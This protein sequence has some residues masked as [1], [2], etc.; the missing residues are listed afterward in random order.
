MYACD[1]KNCPYPL[2][3][4]DVDLHMPNTT[5]SFYEHSEKIYCPQSLSL[6]EA[7]KHLIFGFYE[8]FEGYQFLDPRLM[9]GE[10][11]ILEDLENEFMY[12]IESP[13]YHWRSKM[14][15]NNPN[16]K[17][18]FF[19]L[20]DYAYLKN[21]EE[22]EAKYKEMFPVLTPYPIEQIQSFLP[23][24]IWPQN[25]EIHFGVPDTRDTKLYNIW[26]CFLAAVPISRQ[27][28]VFEFLIFL[29]E[30]REK[31]V[32]WLLKLSKEKSENKE[33]SYRVQD[34]LNKSRMFSQNRIVKKQNFDKKTQTY[35]TL[36]ML[37]E[38]TIRNFIS[39]EKGFS[40]YR[41]IREMEKPE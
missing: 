4:V 41:L 11:V 19:E 32:E 26:Q 35:K 6:E 31:V 22:D 25:P 5:S 14:R 1:E 28:E 38:E 40:L 17:H 9:L 33:L 23:F 7:N 36:D 24:T 16:L 8:G 10:F 15:N 39:K 21:T 27:A 37:I 18:R 13:S 3:E 30:K 29:V 2:D 34:I 20:L 12:R